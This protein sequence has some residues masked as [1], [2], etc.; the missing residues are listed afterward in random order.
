MSAENGMNQAE[1]DVKVES[2]LAQD[3][4]ARLKQ[5]LRQ[6]EAAIVA[7]SGGIDSTFLTH[8]AREVLSGELLA[9]TALSPSVSRHDRELAERQAHEMDLGTD[10]IFVEA[11]EMD[12]PAYRVNDHTRCYHCRV[13]LMDALQRVARERGIT[14]IL[15]GAIAD[16]ADDYRPGETAALERGALFPL[17][18]VGLTKVE[19]RGLARQRGLSQWDRP[20]A[21][22][23]SSRLAY[24]LEVTPQRL[25]MI[26]QAEKVLRSL[27][28]RQFRVRHHG[29]LARIELEP[30]EILPLITQHRA[31]IVERLRALGFKFVTI[32]LQGYR[33]G[34]FNETLKV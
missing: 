6:L 2:S 20:A 25:Q 26:E 24:G 16:D 19:I 3:K 27:G 8:V 10:H 31:L 1:T 13:A 9:V 7:Y 5:R 18:E 29:D 30:D 14:H 17:R 34:S 15:L 4:L 28:L 33:R 23:L 11:R 21:A 32:D 22:C 12:D